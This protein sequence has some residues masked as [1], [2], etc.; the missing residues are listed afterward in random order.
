MAATDVP[1]QPPTYGNFISVLSI[2]GGGIRGL[3]PG[4]IL[5]FLESELQVSRFTHARNMFNC[6]RFCKKVFHSIV[7]F[8]I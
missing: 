2:D 7:G 5:N 1:L 6:C 3:I 4:T 8:S